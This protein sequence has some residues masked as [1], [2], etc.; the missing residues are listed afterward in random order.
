MGRDELEATGFMLP[1]ARRVSRAKKQ[2]LSGYFSRRLPGYSPTGVALRSIEASASGTALRLDRLIHNA[3]WH[4]K[5][6]PATH[7]RER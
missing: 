4:P 5:I 2:G 6:D 1:D 7:K 3:A